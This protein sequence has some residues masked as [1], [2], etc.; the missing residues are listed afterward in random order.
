MPAPM[1]VIVQNVVTQEYFVGDSVWSK[2]PASAL[3]FEVAARAAQFCDGREHVRIIMKFDGAR[4]DWVLPAG[5]PGPVA[6]Q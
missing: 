1:K 2:D 3:N 4:P 6:Q 5:K